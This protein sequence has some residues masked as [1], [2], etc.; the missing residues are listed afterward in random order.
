[1]FT[2]HLSSCTIETMSNNLLITNCRPLSKMENHTHSAILIENGVVTQLGKSVNSPP[3]VRKLDAHG[4]TVSPGFIDIHIQGAGGA[5]VLDGTEASLRTIAQ[6]CVRFG[7]TAF[8]ATTVYKPG[9]DNVHLIE[10]ARCT[11]Q[12]LEE[13]GLQA[14]TWKV[15]SSLRKS[16]V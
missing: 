5:D 13:R 16:G 11:G 1:M 7:V 15:P 4:M 14:F 12:E 3:Q 6:T 8:L 9:Q 10:A 2:F